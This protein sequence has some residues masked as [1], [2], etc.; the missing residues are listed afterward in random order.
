MFWGLGAPCDLISTVSFLFIMR[1]HLSRLASAPEVWLDSVLRAQRLATK[2]NAEFRETGWNVRCGPKFTKFSH[3]VEHPSYFSTPL[4]DCL[5]HVSFRRYSP[6]SLE[7]VEKANKS[8]SFSGPQM[9]P[10]KSTPTF[11]RQIV[12]AIYCPPFGK[13][14]L[15]SVC[16][17]PSAKRG[18]K[19]K[20]R[21]LVGCV[22]W[23]PNF[24]PF[25]DQRLCRFETM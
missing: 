9:F 23:R 14:W 22:K 15:S 16:W 21:I 25:V 11:L 20:R 4:P 5:H 24:K 2:K 10:E 12:S 6:L 1:R 17:S 7:V 3:D 18:N 19:L 13:V 8:K